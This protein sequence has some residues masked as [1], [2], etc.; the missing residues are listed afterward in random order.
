M[1]GLVIFFTQSLLTCFASILW[2]AVFFLRQGVLIVVFA[3]DLAN[4]NTA[5]T[6]PSE[7]ILADQL[8]DVHL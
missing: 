1:S 2:C 4:L 7:M 6:A 5:F 3:R 8:T